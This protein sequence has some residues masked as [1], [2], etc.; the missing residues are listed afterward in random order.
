MELDQVSFLISIVKLHS[1]LISFP[2]LSL[3]VCFPEVVQA[4]Y[5]LI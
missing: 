3:P 1:I 2:L 5:L 4:D